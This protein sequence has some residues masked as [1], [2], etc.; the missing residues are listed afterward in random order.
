MTSG[1][2]Y[3]TIPIEDNETNKISPY[4]KAAYSF[5]ES[6]LNE[7]TL[8]N[9]DSENKETVMES[10]CEILKRATNQ[11]VKAEIFQKSFNKKYFHSNN[12]NRI[13]IHCSLGVSRSSTIAIMYIMKKFSVCFEEVSY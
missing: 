1:I 3:L 5:I 2:K 6:A 11:F 7:G 4:F 13:L 9:G 10:M 8:E 12:N